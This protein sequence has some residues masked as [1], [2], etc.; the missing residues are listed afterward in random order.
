MADIEVS[1]ADGVQ[2]IR[3][4]RPAKKNAFTSA[5]YAVIADALDQGDA[6]PA[7]AAHVFLGSGG[8]FSAGND[9]GDFLAT[10]RGAGGLGQEVERF[11]RSLP[12][13]AKPMIAGVDG[14]AVGVGTTLLFH[15]DLVYA[16]PNAV[17]S[18]PFLD[19]GL[20]P[21]AGSSLLM[22]M[23]M[24]Y[25]RA[26]E[27]LV[28]GDTFSVEQAREAGFVNAIVGAEL[29]EAT[30][31]KVGR[32]LAQKPPE[33]LIQAR[34]L[35]RGETG[36]VLER[37]DQE[38]VAFRDRLASPEAEEAFRAFFEKRKPDFAGARARTSTG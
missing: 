1:L 25:A 38:V 16:T 8:M 4:T 36:L 6:D 23:R 29:L 21:E 28:L 35:M 34:R 13:V 7:V 9:I 18:T 26:F 2:I 24:G 33:A 19:L 12:L 20:V 22:P 30:V 11:I 32:R 5:M 14:P 10:S 37:I 17:F 31:M 3:F 15:C 27:M